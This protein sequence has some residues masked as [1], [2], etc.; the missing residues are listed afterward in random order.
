M[1]QIELFKPV[2]AVPCRKVYLYDGAAFL[3]PWH[4]GRRP[5]MDESYAPQS[6]PKVYVFMETANKEAHGLGMPLPAGR[7]RV[8]KM[9]DADGSLE[10]VGEDVIDHTPREEKIL[11]KLGNAFD[12][13]GERRRTEFSVDRNAQWIVESFEIKVRNR[14]SEPV[15]VRVKERLYRWVNWD[16]ETTSHKFTKQDSASGFFPVT[17]PADGEV[18]V[19]YTV[20]YSW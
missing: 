11:L 1:K 20:R 17:V 2:L 8:H 5:N 6:N 19:T 18:V 3:Q 9:D 14:K 10:L 13:V 12:V 4:G 16:L 7:V 15:E